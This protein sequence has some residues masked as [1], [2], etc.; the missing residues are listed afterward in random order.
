MEY[1]RD[2]VNVTIVRFTAQSVERFKIHKKYK[3]V[4]VNRK[5]YLVKLSYYIQYIIRTADNI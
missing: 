3:N 2:L 5:L 4:T 1:D